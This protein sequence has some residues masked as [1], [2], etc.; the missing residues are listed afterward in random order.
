[1]KNNQRVFMERVDSYDNCEPAVHKLLDRLY[2]WPF[3]PQNF[4]DVLVKPNIMMK[5]DPN[6][7]ITTHPAIIKAVE[8]WVD[9][10]QSQ[11]IQIIGEATRRTNDNNWESYKPIYDHDLRQTF[12]ICTEAISSSLVINVPK[13][14]SHYLMKITCA[15]K[16]LYG[17]VNERMIWHA[18]LKVPDL[19][20]LIFKVSQHIT[21]QFVLVDAIDVLEGFGPGNAGE[22]KH[23]GYIFAGYDP[24][25]VDLTILS[26][27]G[28]SVEESPIHEW[29]EKKSFSLGFAIPNLK[30]DMP[31]ATSDYW[32]EAGD[33]CTY[34]NKCVEICPVDAIIETN[35]YRAE[36][37]I[38]TSKCMNCCVCME[39]CPEG[40]INVKF[41]RS[42]ENEF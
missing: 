18:R 33:K 25:E 9:K 19:A 36:P 13:L 10:K 20:R 8:R 41:R 16:N 23:L 29:A 31:S 26:A 35:V 2:Q 6:D 32:L 37:V 11:Y 17:C 21:P 14:K 28:V 12:E 1:M 39:F 24:V 34:C 3:I 5:S 4:Q 7:G 40:A 27:L 30:M 38:H 15:V 22:R 42:F